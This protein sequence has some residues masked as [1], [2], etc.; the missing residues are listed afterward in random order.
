MNALASPKIFPDTYA[1]L[2]RSSSHTAA[3]ERAARLLPG[4]TTN[5][6][7]QPAGLEFVIERGEGAY[8]IDMD[9]HRRLDFMLG[10]G[11]LVLG[12]AHPRIVETIAQQAARGTHY[13]GLAQRAVELAER[14]AR[15]V[16]SA[17]MVRFAGSGTEATMHAIRLARAVTGREGFVKFDG[18]WHGHS[19]LAAWSM[20][21]SPTQIPTPYAESAGIQRG[22][23][24]DLVVLRYNDAAAVRELLRAHPQ[25]F[26]AIICE[27]AQRALSPQ[28]GF[29]ETLREECTKAG[30]VLIFDEVV[31]G[32]RIAPGGAQE[33]YGVVP[34]LT[35][36]GKALSGGLPLAAL[37]GK[38]WLMEH[39]TPGS[40][41]SMFSFHCGTFNG[42][43][44]AIEC[45]HT[46][47]DIMIDEGG[48]E[49]LGKLGDLA[50]EKVGAVFKDLGLTAQITGV[51]PMFHYYFTEE[52][53]IDQT[54]ARRSNI[55][56]GNAIHRHMYAAGIYR[57]AAKTYLC[58]VHTPD[59]LDEY[60]SVLRWAA[61]TSLR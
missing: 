58:L 60:C 2:K 11:P 27:P 4:G 37:V 20:E 25:R 7:M 38:R 24:D 21:S 35:T 12:H 14:I 28:P 30:V 48:I 22:V 54:V 55:A 5:S 1:T 36:L 32:F 26:A 33:K 46:T 23:S 41:P 6:L 59:H 40:D 50:R 51:G 42:S 49:T 9:G 17:E 8:V 13:F 47:M 3:Y 45:A 61:A 19:D 31:T 52:E 18:A 57:Q 34:D 39:L 10:A 29:L 16:P 44:L 53:V 56:L 15:H 43:P